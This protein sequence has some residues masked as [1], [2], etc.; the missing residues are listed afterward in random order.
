MTFDKC[1]NAREVMSIDRMAGKVKDFIAD[2]CLEQKS[3]G[4]DYNGY[5]WGSWRH[6]YLLAP[7]KVKELQALIEGKKA[8][9]AKA[10]KTDEEKEE[11]WAKRLA[12][13]TG[14]SIERAREIA[15]EKI[16][17]KTEQWN[18]LNQRQFNRGYS[19][20]RSR[21]MNAIDRSNPLR[22][23][24]D[25]DHAMAILAASYR[26]NNTDYDGLLDENRWEAQ[27]GNMDYEEVRSDARA[28][29]AAEVAEGVK[30]M[31]GAI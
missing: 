23:I 5:G 30:R 31:V 27:M 16:N 22:Y 17:A 19:V 2:N 7:A 29:V 1:K 24:K 3:Q 4:E 21:L 10:T 18:Q 26:H 12:K 20:K 15:L 6:C 28:K 11:A 25:K 13:L 9:K 14:I 8:E